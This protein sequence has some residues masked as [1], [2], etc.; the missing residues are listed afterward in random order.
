MLVFIKS[1]KKVGIVKTDNFIEKEDFKKNN[2]NE[3][4][5]K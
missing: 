4:I 3:F 1:V 2:Q 5:I